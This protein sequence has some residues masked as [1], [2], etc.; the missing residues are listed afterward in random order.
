MT[1]S[2]TTTRTCP[3]DDHWP[4]RIMLPMIDGPRLKHP[5][6]VMMYRAGITPRKIAELNRIPLRRVRDYLNRVRRNH[7]DLL[8]GRLIFH[9]Q[10]RPDPK[11][12]AAPDSRWK[13]GLESYLA[14]TTEHGRRPTTGDPAEFPLAHWLTTQRSHHR[15]G[16]LAESRARRLD[17]AVPD[18]QIDTRTL[19]AG[20]RT[21]G[22]PVVATAR[23]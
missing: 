22:R 14:F 10:P 9:D 11:R 21:V 5:E 6:W 18:W 13:A 12:R 20:G 23:A 17:E 16:R 7:P 4:R 3:R 1:T 15:H 2:P 19:N 8:A